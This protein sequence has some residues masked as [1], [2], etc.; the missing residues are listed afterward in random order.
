MN[1]VL[2][3]F[4]FGLLVIFGCVEPAEHLTKEELVEKID[5]STV[6]PEEQIIIVKGNP[7]VSLVKISAYEKGGKWRFPV[8]NHTDEFIGIG[9]HSD[10]FMKLNNSHLML[11]DDDETVWL[12]PMME[13][14]QTVLF[15]AIYSREI[16][17]CSAS[18]VMVLGRKYQLTRLHDGS[19]FENDDKW[20]IGLE[21]ENGCLKR[22]VIYLDGYFYDLEEEQI[23]LFRNDNTILFGF[24]DI[25]ASP[26]VEVIGTV[27]A[28]EAVGKNVTPLVE[29][30]IELKFS[31]PVPKT[32]FGC[33]NDG[34][35]VEDGKRITTEA[36]GVEW[37]VTQ[38][39]NDSMELGI[40]EQFETLIEW[41]YTT[42]IQ[43]TNKRWYVHTHECHGD[44]CEQIYTNTE[45]KN[46]TVRF[47]SG[48]TKPIDGKYVHVW[49]S[50]T[51]G[52]FP[53]HSTASV[54]S[55]RVLIDSDEAEF[56]WKDGNL[57]SLSVPE[58]SPAFEKL[59]G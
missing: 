28:E 53:Y 43:T 15:D 24:K 49:D 25:E 13:K 57:V 55:K 16:K 44:F 2:A 46:E 27:P 31:H 30:V 4:V 5:T 48:E 56:T 18:E 20:K 29:K 32:C 12:H 58:N 21:K 22:I 42:I 50:I 26:Y 8:E 34:L 3:L 33:L 52:P 17:N 23:S 59:F 7:N 47:R 10:A 54:L 14:N 19:S 9:L 41:N 37:V 39:V 38:A 6:L 35:L 11:L 40:E 45:D 1:K 51:R 36:N